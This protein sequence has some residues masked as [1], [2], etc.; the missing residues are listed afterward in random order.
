MRSSIIDV[1]TD[2][3]CKL[4][5]GPAG[6][7]VVFLLPDGRKLHI[8][9][10]LG[11]GTNN[12]AELMAVKIALETLQDDYWEEH[13]AIHTDSQLV[14]G[15]LRDGWKVNTNKG[16]ISETKRLLSCFTFVSFVKVKGHSGNTLNE[17]ADH[18]A[19]EA[20]FEIEINTW[21]DQ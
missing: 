11:S 19:Q 7:G 16:L 3:A 12:Q 9:R 5:P 15:W 8:S 21:S 13:I 6:A 14:I 20:A 1:Y 17:E 10:Y 2:G 18:L 4:N